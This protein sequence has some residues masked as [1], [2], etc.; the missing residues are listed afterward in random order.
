MR[1]IPQRLL[2][3]ALATLLLLSC[4]V[5][6]AFGATESTH[7]QFPETVPLPQT[8]NIG[9]RFVYKYFHVLPATS[10]DLA[11]KSTHGIP[12][13]VVTVLD[14]TGS[15]DGPSSVAPPAFVLNSS[16]SVRSKVALFQVE[17][18]LGGGWITVPEGW[19]VVSAVA[20]AQGSWGATFV[21]PDGASHGWILIDGSGPGTTEV[22]SAAEGYFPGAYQLENEIIPGTL[23]RDSTLSPEPYAF[24]RPD[25]CTALV[26][27]KSGGLA[28]ISVR[29]FGRDGITSFSVALPAS[30]ATL[31]AFLFDAY[32]KE[33]PVLKCVKNVK[34]W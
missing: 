24:V 25:P 15:L 30:E 12:A 2:V 8:A 20:G 5:A 16:A 7:W 19:R 10:N 33:H 3:S 21:A 6:D 26:S 4:V 11:G 28:I 14:G 23:T 29:Q 22:F 17:T 13:M 31:Q 1:T 27:Y 18:G 32:R 9:T 34:D